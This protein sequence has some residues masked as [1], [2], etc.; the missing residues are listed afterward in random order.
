MSKVLLQI[1]WLRT[2]PLLSHVVVDETKSSEKLEA[3]A[4]NQISW[5][6]Q[7][8]CWFPT[9]SKFTCMRHGV[10]EFCG[11]DLRQQARRGDALG[12]DL[13]RHG[14]DAHHRYAEW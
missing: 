7:I 5:L 9:A 6:C 3:L 13:L 14:R 12:D 1:S 10:E 8:Q 4:A 11:D 2:N